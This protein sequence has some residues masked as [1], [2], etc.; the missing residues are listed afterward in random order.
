MQDPGNGMLGINL[1]FNLPHEAQRSCLRPGN[2]FTELVAQASNSG[3]SSPP[4]ASF[5]SHF[6]FNFSHS[7]TAP[8]KPSIRTTATHAPRLRIISKMTLETRNKR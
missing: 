7:V 4:R 2:L 6:L 1:Q 5:L 8:T 3:R